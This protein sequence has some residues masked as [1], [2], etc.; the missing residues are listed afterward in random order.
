MAKRQTDLQR[1]INKIDSLEDAE[2]RDVLEYISMME[3]TNRA[4]TSRGARDDE[5]IAMLAEAYENKRARQAFEWEAV[6][7]RA[8]RRATALSIRT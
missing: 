6:R 2:I 8:E 3:S 1:L 7:R 4:E 5:L